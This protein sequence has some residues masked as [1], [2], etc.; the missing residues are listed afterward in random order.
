MR[1][2]VEVAQLREQIGH[3]V[4]TADPAAVDA[5]PRRSAISA[6]ER[7]RDRRGVEPQRGAAAAG[8]A[9]VRPSCREV[10]TKAAIAAPLFGG[11]C[12]ASVAVQRATCRRTARISSGESGRRPAAAAG[13]SAGYA[14]SG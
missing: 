8:S 5:A 11:G 7:L 1:R 2:R 13:G 4:S 12:S 10:H 14:C 9:R 3:A 6:S